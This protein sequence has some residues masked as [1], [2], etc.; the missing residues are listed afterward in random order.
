MSTFTINPAPLNYINNVY[1]IVS[2]I[3]ILFIIAYHK[4]LPSVGI[5]DNSREQCSVGIVENY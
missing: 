3:V 2:G 1:N 4:Q 5:V